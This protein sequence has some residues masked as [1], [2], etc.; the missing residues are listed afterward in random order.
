[1]PLNNQSMNDIMGSLELPKVS[2]LNRNESFGPI[3]DNKN[4]TI[5]K[6]M[7]SNGPVVT[8]SI[9]DPSRNY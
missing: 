1:M 2:L 7:T 5:N 8:N 6:T 9:I 4:R 3:N